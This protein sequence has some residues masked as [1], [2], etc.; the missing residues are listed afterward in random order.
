MKKFYLTT[1]LYYVNSVPHIGHAYT[2]IAAD[3]LCRYKKQTGKEVFFLTG[4]DE[5]G[6][7][8]EKAAAAAGKTP[9]EW[10]DN[11][12]GKFKELWQKLNIEYDGFIRTTDPRHTRPVQLAFEKMIKTGDIYKGSYSGNYCFSCE[13]YIDDTEAVN[14]C[15]PVH[16]TKLTEVKEETYFFKLSKYQ[17]AL[18]NLYKQNPDFLSPHFRASEISNFVKGGL[19][20]L[21]VT[22]TKVAWGIPLLSDPGHTIYVWFD[23]LLNYITAIGYEQ[24]SEGKD[25]AEFQALWPADVHFIGKEIYR[26]HAVIWPAMLMALGL[27]APK[28]VFAHGWWTVEGEKMSKSRGNIV[29]PVEMAD[30]YGVDALRYFLFRE[31]PFGSDGDFSIQS[32][33]TRFNADLANDLGN[34]VSRV[35]NMTGKLMDLPEGEEACDLLS[36][37]DAAEK[38]IETHMDALAFDK[39]LDE[40]WGLTSAMNKY[41]DDT[42]PW[43]LV[44]T[45]EAAAKK[46]LGEIIYTLRRVGKYIT[47]FMPSTGPE[48]LKRLAP[49]K[50]EKYPPLFPRLETK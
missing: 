5:H 17:D 46:V 32:F 11:V 47:P 39:A 3:I 40:I 10:A 20:D 37:A 30:K 38:N 50:A 23:A 48:I 13:A 29:D 12:T 4:T 18:L 16:K 24:F 49:G 42:K 7:N 44:K 36:K 33:L 14:G 26:F 34:L 25:A 19:K 45:D 41:L 22:R 43:T 35:L 2:T 28:K 31:V 9:Q 1:P 15:C 8:I 6:A 27:G 21:S